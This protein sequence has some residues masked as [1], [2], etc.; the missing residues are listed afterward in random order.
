MIFSLSSANLQ[1][2]NESM[3]PSHSVLQHLRLTDGRT[4]PDRSNV[5]VPFSLTKKC[6]TRI[7]KSYKHHGRQ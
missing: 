2:A 3:P 7:A 1:R 4:G 6:T 5:L